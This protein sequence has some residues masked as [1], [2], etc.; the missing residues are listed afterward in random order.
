MPFLPSGLRENTPVSARKSRTPGQRT[1][2]SAGCEAKPDGDRSH[3][4]RPTGNRSRGARWYGD[5]RYRSESGPRHRPGAL[6][7]LLLRVS[8]ADREVLWLYLVT[9]LGIWTTAY[10]ARWLFPADHNSRAAGPL[11]A[12]F[13]QWDWYFY[14]HIAK[15]GYFPGQGEFLRSTLDHREAFL[16]G[17]PLVLRAVHTV[18]TNWTAA[19]LLISFA[20]G[21]V[22]V[23]AL[24][25]ITRLHLPDHGAA[26]APWPSCCSR[27][28]R[29]SWPPATPRRS[30]SPSHCPPGS[31]PSGATGRS[32]PR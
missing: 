24:S 15:D 6:R 13:Q 32:P 14:L 31:P 7:S 21:A 25:R 12:P 8:P 26:G 20:A 28:A 23:L 18:V 3:G 22:A 30:S 10:C 2:S 19:G 5:S 17:F 9:R 29:S 4:D 11:L 27:R 1:H 16:P